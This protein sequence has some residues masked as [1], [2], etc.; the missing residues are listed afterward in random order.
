[1]N[2]IFYKLQD[3]VNDVKKLKTLTATATYE[4]L[5][6]QGTLKAPTSKIAPV[7]EFG[8]DI[9]YFNGYNYCYIADFGRYYFVDDMISI[10]VSVTS[11][12]LRVDVLTSFLNQEGAGRLQ[13]YVTRSENY[14]LINIYDERVPYAPTRAVVDYKPTM[15]PSGSL[16]NFSFKTNDVVGNVAFNY[17]FEVMNSN[18]Y[19]SL[20]QPDIPYKT[21]TY[22]LDD[23]MPRV[24][25][26]RLAP[27]NHSV[28]YVGEMT[29]IGHLLDACVKSEELRSN[30]IYLTAYPFALPTVGEYPTGLEPIVYGKDNKNITY[31]VGNN[32]VTLECLKSRSNESGYLV[33]A[34]FELNIPATISSSVDPSVLTDKSLVSYEIYL[35]YY[36]YVNI[37]CEYRGHRLIVYYTIHYSD[38]IGTV[39][40]ADI[41][42][43]IDA[44]YVILNKQVQLG[45]QIPLDGSNNQELLARKQASLLNTVVSVAGGALTTY[46]GYKTGNVRMAMYGVAGIAGGVASYANTQIKAID[47][48]ET[49]VPSG[50]IGSYSPQEVRIRFTYQPTQSDFYR[51]Y[52]EHFN[53]K[54][55]S[56]VTY[57]S[58][59]SGYTEIDRL[60][61]E[62]T[63]QS[64]FG[65]LT[66]ITYTE[67]E[68]LEKLC[69]TGVY[70]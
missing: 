13:A 51:P 37:P 27:Y 7:I 54:P 29:M 39:N 38:G 35:P 47:K 17:V 58:N 23:I 42:D 49:T 14:G 69:R 8:Q 70:L 66:D 30:I 32:D 64:V 9:T 60:H 15:T 61:V 16:V 50:S 26:Y 18:Q 28:I 68:E 20:I 46:A 67:Y 24:A 3:E 41:S 40:V 36:G 56:M 12:S 11:I 63:K 62:G 48:A 22:D 52:F 53:G 34:D 43:T 57:L 2:I 1:M 33:L 25:D 65:Y 45:V 21:M 55:C 10:R 5:T 44:P 59:L 4:P 31:K 19:Q 6:V